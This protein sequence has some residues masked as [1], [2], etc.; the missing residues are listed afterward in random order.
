MKPFFGVAILLLVSIPVLAQIPNP[1]FESWNAD[2]T[3]VGW[4][5][6]SSPAYRTVTRTSPGHSG[7]Y[8]LEGMVASV[9]FY[10]FSPGIYAGPNGVIPYAQRPAALTGWY[11]SF[12]ASP[13]DALHISVSMFQAVTLTPVAVGAALLAGTVQNFTQFSVNLTYLSSATPD[14]AI[15]TFTTVWNTGSDFPTPGTYFVL[16]DIAFGT[17]TAVDQ[18][19]AAAP[20]SFALLQN[21]PNPFNP[22]TV[23]RYQISGSSPVRLAVYDLLGRELAVL[24]NETK[25]PG[26][27]SVR[28]DGSSLPS[29][30]YLYRLEA[31]TFAYTRRM[32]LVK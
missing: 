9:G 14:S 18:P 30:V 16:D 19:A 11:K 15:I 8:A 10:G 29:G 12:P 32:A 31:G 23:I 20:S 1:G 27:Y 25:A 17:G 13:N 22:S 28:F 3:V 26:S 21:Y 24:V 7:A 5:T 2:T 6:N 4:L